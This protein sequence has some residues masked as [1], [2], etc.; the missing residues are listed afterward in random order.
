MTRRE[1]ILKAAQ[2]AFLKYG[3][4]KITLDDIAQE[5]GINKTALYYYFKNKDEILGQM[6][7]MKYNEFREQVDSAV[8]EADDI[9]IKLRTFM[10]MKINLMLENMPFIN[11]FEKEGLPSR[12]KKFLTEHRQKIMDFDFKLIKGIIDKGQR[13]NR[14]SS[15]LSE[16]LVLMILGVTYGSFMGK[17]MEHADWNIEAM[18]DT[19]IEI[20]LK[21]IE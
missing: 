15:Q 1:E 7:L 2:H 4:N 14:I 16:S 21:E 19:T 11:L 8:M 3:L 13:R 5:C 18:V 10:L 9:R 6:F 12:A 17:F 20:I